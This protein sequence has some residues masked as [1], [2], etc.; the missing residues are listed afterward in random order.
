MV[1]MFLF[2][3]SI[4]FFT[5][6]I[7]RRPVIEEHVTLVLPLD[8]GEAMPDAEWREMLATAESDN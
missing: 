7:F 2:G 5:A 8:Y 1:L 4:G 3:L 6:C